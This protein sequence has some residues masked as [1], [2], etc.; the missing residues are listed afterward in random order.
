MSPSI[1]TQSNIKKAFTL[2]ELL[3]VIGIIALLISIL[4]PSL[5][6]ARQQAASVK[7][8][9]NIRN[10]GNAIAMYVNENR[11]YYPPGAWAERPNV[12]RTR[13]VDAI[14]PHIRN[15]DIF[16]CPSLDPVWYP[17]MNKAFNHTTDIVPDAQKPNPPYATWA[18]QGVKYFGG[19]GYNYQYLGNGRHDPAA[20][21]P[22][23]RTAFLQRAS[24]IRSSSRT[25]AVADTR[26]TNAVA[27]PYNG[28]G[29]YVI[30]PPLQSY[31]LGSKGGRRNLSGNPVDRDTNNYGYRNGSGSRASN[32]DP[33]LKGKSAYR[34]LPDERHRGRI[35]VAFC[36][37]HGEMLTLDQIDDS[38]GDGVRDNGLWTGLDIADHGPSG[39]ENR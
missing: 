11:G 36:D 20:A 14:Y 10:I 17:N 7:C 38:N 6:I 13:W 29:V 5:N 4:L 19:Y 9:S 3:V 30:D 27:N 39:L 8:L 22:N 25:V 37:G 31:N 33:S 26:G 16:V 21:D 23:Y 15:T 2:V 32:E 18:P 34:S 28:D 1:F 35:A 12:A 24:K